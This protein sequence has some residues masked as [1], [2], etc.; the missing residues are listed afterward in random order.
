MSLHASEQNTNLTE[1]SSLLFTKILGSRKKCSSRFLFLTSVKVKP[2]SVN[3]GKRSEISGEQGL[4]FAKQFDRSELFCIYNFSLYLYMSL[5][6]H[7]D[8]NPEFQNPASGCLQRCMDLCL[9]LYNLP[10]SSCSLAQCTQ[11]IVTN[12]MPAFER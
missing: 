2:Q 1:P 6:L 3:Y 8:C 5:I 7:G 12:A 11:I 10:L 4:L 9:N